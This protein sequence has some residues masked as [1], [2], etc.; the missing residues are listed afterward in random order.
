MHEL[1]SLTDQQL[2]DLCLKGEDSAWSE[3]IRRYRRV[4]YAVPQR[5]G[6]PPEECA[7]VFQ[8]VSMLL[9]E[10]L[11]SVRDP[12]RLAGWLT[13][14]CRREA[15]LVS[16]TASERARRWVPI[17]A[18]DDDPGADAARRL[19]DVRPLADEECA[20]I[21]RAR[22]LHEALD[23]L[24]ERCR[25]LLSALLHDEDG[26]SYDRIAKQLGMSRGSIGPTRARCLA[27]LREQLRDQGLD[28]L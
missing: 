17:D 25:L 16:R 4:I 20:E 10:R 27:R 24:S 28:G 14:T 15:W 11:S 18:D 21:E 22:I 9:F 7:E 6:L 8:R 13:T 19:T 26:G 12:G 2:V 23:A 1:G 5:M 3:L